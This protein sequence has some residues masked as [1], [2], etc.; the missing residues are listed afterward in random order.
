MLYRLR[1][2]QLTERIFVTLA[3]ED[4]IGLQDLIANYGWAL[5]TGDVEALVACFTPMLS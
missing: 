3:I 4:R 1:S 5:D 2:G